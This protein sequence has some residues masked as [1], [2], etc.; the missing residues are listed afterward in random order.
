M[1][2]ERE[3]RQL[4]CSSWVTRARLEPA[5]AVE[6]EYSRETLLLL[7]VDRPFQVSRIAVAYL[8]EEWFASQLQI[9]PTTRSGYRFALDKHVLPK[10]GST[11]I[12]DVSHGA[13]QIWVNQLAEK[14]GPS[15]VRQIHPVLFG[16]FKFAIRDGRL[17]KNPSVDIRLPRLQKNKRGSLT[18][19]Q[20]RALVKECGDWGQV[21]ELSGVHRLEVGGDGRA[22]TRSRRP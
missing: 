9:K 17:V 8:A 16:I 20:V 15:M 1:R 6:C 2:S 18:H 5:R 11:P 4:L 14:L 19:A 13:V 7:R 22:Q 3:F 21:V 12:A 10:W